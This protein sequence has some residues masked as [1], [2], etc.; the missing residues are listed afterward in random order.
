MLRT[1]Y[2]RTSLVAAVILVAGGSAA[3]QSIRHVDDDASTNGDGLTWD[4]SYKYLQDALLEAASDPGIT[5]IRVAGGTYK[6]DR[7]ESGG[8]TPGERLATFQL[9]DNVSVEG[10][11]AGLA[12]PISPD[13]RD[14]VA[15]ESTLSGD[16]AGNDDPADFP[17]GL[18]FEENACRV[19][20]GS[21]TG[22][23]ASLDGFTVTAGRAEHT[24]LPRWSGGGL[25]N[26]GGSPTVAN[27]IFQG[28]A[29]MATGGG[30]CNVNS[31]PTLISCRL[32]GNDAHYGGGM[33][34]VLADPVLINCIFSGNRATSEG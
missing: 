11:Y 13:D 19:V 15:Y 1:T 26:E 5:E 4:T 20:T 28:N 14:L 24:L 10:G 34:N 29:A 9:L 25:Y 16:L 2:V 32:L 23:T 3:G 33:E 30:V 8:V 17:D 27:C 12:N 6:P 21:G 31:A 18:T 22:P 7:D